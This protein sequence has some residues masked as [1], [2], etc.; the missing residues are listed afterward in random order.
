MR[1]RE[2]ADNSGVPYETVRY[3]GMLDHDPQT[4]EQLSAA[5]E[6]PPSHLRELLY[7]D[8]DPLSVPTPTLATVGRS[9]TRRRTMRSAHSTSSP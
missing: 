9:L 4:L 6:W 3:F 1:P 8:A 2:L 5:L 7:E